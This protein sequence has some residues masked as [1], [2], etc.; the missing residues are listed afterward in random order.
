[1]HF[2]IKLSLYD[3]AFGVKPAPVTSVRTDFFYASLLPPTPHIYIVGHMSD[4]SDASDAVSTP[5]TVF[6]RVAASAAWKRLNRLMPALAAAVIL[7]MGFH[8][9]RGDACRAYSRRMGAHV[10]HRRHCQRGCAGSAG[11]LDQYS[12]FGQRQCGRVREP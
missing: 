11:R 7:L 4:A 9:D 10:S 3:L 8:A 12:A 1:M 6:S 5:L 2:S